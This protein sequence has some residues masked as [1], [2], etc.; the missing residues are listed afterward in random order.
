MLCKYTINSN[1]HKYWAS[2]NEQISMHDERCSKILNLSKYNLKKKI[3]CVNFR[4]T[5]T[6]LLVCQLFSVDD[7][8]VERKKWY[9]KCEPEAEKK[10]VILT[11]W[12]LVY[13]IAIAHLACIPSMVALEANAF[14]DSN[15]KNMLTAKKGYSA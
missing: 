14:G 7:W 13:R 12:C 11:I 5:S 8:K 3:Y 6:K 4:P 9:K 10:L 15:H 1:P 2:K